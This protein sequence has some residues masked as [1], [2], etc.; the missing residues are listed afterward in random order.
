MPVDKDERA[1]VGPRKEGEDGRKTYDA[2]D[3]VLRIERLVR[4]DD[5]RSR[6]RN[7]REKKGDEGSAK[8]RPLH[9]RRR[10]GR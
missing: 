10:C 3:K 5:L 6:E 9:R 2:A 1:A 7:K 4:A 8:G